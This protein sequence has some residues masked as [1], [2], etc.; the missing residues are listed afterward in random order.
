MQA[1][2]REGE[3]GAPICTWCLRPTLRF[4]SKG[5]VV[6]TSG[7]GGAFGEMALV[8]SR[9]AP[10]ATAETEVAHNSH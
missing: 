4:Q 9:H 6:E 10:A 8:I 7:V 2:M 5:S 3:T 1:I